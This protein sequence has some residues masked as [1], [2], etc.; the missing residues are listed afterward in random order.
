MRRRPWTRLL[1]G[2]MLYELIGPLIVFYGARALGVDQVVALLLGSALSL[3][4]AAQQIR[5]ERRISGVTIFVLA[6]MLLTVLMSFVAGSPRVLLVRDAWGT[7]ALGL[8]LLA[9]LFLR[10][11]FLYEGTRLV[12][13]A[14]QRETW[15]AS[16][17]RSAPL[18]RLL[19][20]G[21]AV[22]GCAFLAD[23]ALRVLMALYL[24]I[25]VVPLLD[26][27]LLVVTLL[28]L[29]VAMR[30]GG[31]AYLRG[32]GLRLQGTALHPHPPT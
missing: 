25:D 8:W 29:A 17:E 9:T 10:R 15:E 28:A 3:V 18:R 26:D 27:V 11:P 20:V 21:T 32:R 22:C 6:T 5:A 1:T 16:W 12:S 30:R 19:R 14:D 2:A 23:A 4:G 7:A 24:P 13:D 31:R